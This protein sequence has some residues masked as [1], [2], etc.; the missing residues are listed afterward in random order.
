[1]IKEF[2]VE[3]TD[4]Q[5]TVYVKLKE[6]NDRLGILK[7]RFSTSDVLEELKQQG[8]VPGPCTQESVIKNW[9][10]K[11]LE[12]T[13]VFE[14]KKLDKPA[15]PVTLKEEKSVQPKSTRKRRTRSSTKK[16]STED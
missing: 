11:L 2:K 8:H 4:E 12:G 10:P 5:L 14:K 16:V 6:R 13:W 9:H 7:T 15:K 1:M 3:K